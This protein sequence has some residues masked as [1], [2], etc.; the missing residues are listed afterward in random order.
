MERAN[1]DVKEA[2]KKSGVRQWELAI[3]CGY[4]AS[5]FVTKLRQELPED[6]KLKMFSLIEEIAEEKRG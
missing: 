2:L 6:E 1:N 4:S 3:K 5:H